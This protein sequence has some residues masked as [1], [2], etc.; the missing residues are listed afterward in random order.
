MSRLMPGKPVPDLS[1][2]LVGGGT[3]TLSEQTPET[4]TVVE[5]YRGYHCPRCKSQLLDID[6]KV[7]RYAERGCGVIAISTDPQD[8]A[9]KTVAEWGVHQLPVAY[10]LSLDQARSWGLYISNAF[11]E[12]E[13]R[14]F[15]EPGL[16]LI[17]PD[18]T[19][20]SNVIHTTPFHR[21]HHADVL[22]AVDMIRARNYP[23][24]GDADA[25]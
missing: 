17:R 11:Q 2:P 7:A 10:G 16:F 5:V 3:W 6:H 24:R 22:E 21:H 9:E 18:M 15:A 13:T 12:K 14:H 4:F 8:R 25:A 20:Y 1:L 19:L 23:P